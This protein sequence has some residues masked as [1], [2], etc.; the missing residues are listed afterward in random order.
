MD[1]LVKL[2]VAYY[3]QGFVN[4]KKRYEDYFGGDQSEIIIYLGTWTSEPFAARINRRAQIIGTPRIMMGTRYT[5]YVKANHK[6][7]ETIKIEFMNP[8]YP[9][10]I[11]II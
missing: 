4:I 8:N 2:G 11:L 6:L 10:S 5:E 9:N 7:G 1:I 3:T